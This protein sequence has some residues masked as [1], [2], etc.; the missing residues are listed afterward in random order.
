M[1]GVAL[2]ERLVV[3]VHV[4]GIDDRV[5]RGQQPGL[6]VDQGP[7]AVEGEDVEPVEVDGGHADLPVARLGTRMARAQHIDRRRRLTGRPGILRA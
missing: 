4:A 2:E 1:A 7:V 3:R 6:P 5:Q